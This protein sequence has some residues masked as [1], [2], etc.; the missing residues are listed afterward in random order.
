MSRGAPK[1]IRTANVVKSFRLTPIEAV[2]LENF[3]MEHD[4]SISDLVRASMRMALSS[5]EQLMSALRLG[6]ERE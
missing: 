6:G 1:K 5:P 4:I 2:D 3:C